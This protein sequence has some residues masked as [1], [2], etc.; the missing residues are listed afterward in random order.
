MLSDVETRKQELFAE[1]QEEK[2][3]LKDDYEQAVALLAEEQ[4]EDYMRQKI[5][6]EKEYKAEKQSLL[7]DFR[8][9]NIALKKREAALKGR[10]YVPHREMS[11]LYRLRRGAD[12]ESII[13]TRPQEKPVRRNVISG[14]RDNDT[15]YTDRTKLG[16][17][18]MKYGNRY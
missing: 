8:R 13:G 12:K 18:T 4:P 1:Y 16:I 3:R 11:T 14:S 6:L 10:R 17:A 15:S 5:Q 7:A 9:I 2:Q